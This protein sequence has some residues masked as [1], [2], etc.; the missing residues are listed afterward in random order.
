MQV[1]YLVRISLPDEGWGVN[2]HS[3]GIT[4]RPLREITGHAV[5]NETFFDDVPIPKSQILGEINK[6]WYVA[7]VLWNMR[8]R[9]Q[10]GPLQ[11]K[12]PSATL[13]R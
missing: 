11:A 3:P 12:I 4:I 7:W 5:F 1:E 8:G 10:A 13:S 9:A 6:G 2:M